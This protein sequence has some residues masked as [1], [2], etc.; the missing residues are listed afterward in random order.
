METE[1]EKIRQR[2]LKFG[3]PDLP[4]TANVSEAEKRKLRQARFGNPNN[5]T[6]RSNK[7]SQLSQVNEILNLI[8]GGTR[9]Y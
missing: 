8:I 9:G 5:R 4:S 1:E 6:Q 7:A 2:R 3:E